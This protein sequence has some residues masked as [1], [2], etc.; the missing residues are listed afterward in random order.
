MRV[1]L[2]SL[3]ALLALLALLPAPAAAWTEANVQSISATV[4]VASDGRATVR[5][6]LTV[7]IGGGWLEGIDVDGLDAD[8]V[9]SEAEPPWARSTTDPTLVWTPAVRVRGDG[10][11]RLSFPGRGSPRRGTLL[12]G[13]T[14]DTALAGRGT[15]PI[16]DG[17]VRVSWTL[18]GWRTGIDGVEVTLVT[19]N[20]AEPA[21][22][23][24]DGPEAADEHEI[25]ENSDAVA[26]TVRRIHLPRTIPWTVAV[27]LPA[28]AMDPALRGPS[29]ATPR[30]APPARA[31]ERPGE[32]VLS[33][34]LLVLF[35]S[36]ASRLSFVA[37]CRAR[38]LSPR[39]L[40]PGPTWLIAPG[41]GVLAALGVASATNEPLLSVV[42]LTGITALA[43]VRSPGRSTDADE[44]TVAETET[45]TET[46][47]ATAVLATARKSGL[48][49]LLIGSPVLDLTTVFGV[50]SFALLSFS[51]LFLGGLL[52]HPSAFGLAC[53]GL[54]AIPFLSATRFHL[55]PSPCE[56]FRALADFASRRVDVSPLALRLICQRTTGG[57][58]L[59]RLRLVTDA[60]RP[61]LIRLD[62]LMV[63]RPVL[64]GFEL[65]PMLLVVTDD[66]SEAEA[67][68][69]SAVTAR[70]IDGPNGRRA[71]LIA[72]PQPN[73]DTIVRSLAERLVDT[74]ET[75]VGA[76]LAA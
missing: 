61:G 49:S 35:S 57:R 29:V 54:L 48:M 32:A 1:A 19:P 12:I 43:L 64:G 36:L 70:A 73:A 52:T 23:M 24:G 63:P 41:A 16:D 37:A 14:Y 69:A 18:P 13:L 72:L 33:L 60:A 21:P 62:V 17:R 76:L 9:L 74:D 55:P 42:L 51:A 65:A 34:V 27:D 11:V 58:L 30:N 5:L 44:E 59:P 40:I 22:S 67:L 2:A 31:D 71:R 50:V 7:R 66:G 56:E 45:E 8:L 39:A 47:R 53:M 46:Q 4:D 20:G 28:E 6:V 68:V 15:T 25:V 26:H 38:G 3:L 10:S 75:V